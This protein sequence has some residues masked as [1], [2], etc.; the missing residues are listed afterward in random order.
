MGRDTQVPD[1]FVKHT[2]LSNRNAAGPPPDTYCQIYV[3]NLPS[4][5]M[6]LFSLAEFFGTMG[7][8]KV[9]RQINTGSVP[10]T[11][12]VDVQPA[13]LLHLHSKSG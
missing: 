7:A 6:D 10:F 2:V 9:I 3:A 13:F 5:G 8:I 4:Q 1:V 12:V 11:I